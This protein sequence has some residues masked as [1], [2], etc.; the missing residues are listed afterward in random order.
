MFKTLSLAGATL[1]LAASLIAQPAAA[2]QPPSTSAGLVITQTD[3]YSMSFNPLTYVV[4]Q[5]ENQSEAPLGVKTIAVS[6][7]A[8]DG[9]TIGTANAFTKPS[10]LEPGQR[11]GWVAFVQGTPNLPQ[12]SGPPSVHVDVESGPPHPASFLPP[13]V[14]DLRFEGVT[15]QPPTQYN[16][17]TRIVGQVVNTSSQSVQRP[18]IIGSILSTVPEAEGDLID[19]G[20]GI[21]NLE[22][23]APGQSAPFQITLNQGG[24]SVVRGFARYELYAEARVAR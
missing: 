1:A 20:G 15:V 24:T 16:S 14:H 3:M 5:I 8:P 21:A 12:S 2:A 13:V 11:S 23:L 7:L 4:G 17:L 10:F 19:V 22:T 18:T 9:S 6:V